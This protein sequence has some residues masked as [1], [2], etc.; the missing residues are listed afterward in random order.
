[1]VSLRK[2]K[3]AEKFGLIWIDAHCDA[4][5]PETSPSQN[6]HGMP[7]AGLMGYGPKSWSQFLNIAKKVKPEHIVQIGI[8]SFEK[9]EYALLKKLG[10]KVYEMHEVG[11]RTFK[12]IFEEAYAYLSECTD[13]IGIS[14]DVDSIDPEYAPGV[15]TPE[16]GGLDPVEVLT[17]LRSIVHRPKITALEL[18]EY[19]PDADVNHKTRRLIF[20]ILATLLE[21]QPSLL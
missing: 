14:F 18:V 2:K 20:Q 7:I 19:N 12:S 16:A 13:G 21:P 15:A 17:T 6:Y 10:V 9:E 4:H 5:T 8:R 11:C 3:M 1:V